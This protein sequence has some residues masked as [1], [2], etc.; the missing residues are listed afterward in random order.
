MTAVTSGT[1][2]PFANSVL[3]IAAGGLAMNLAYKVFCEKNENKIYCLQQQILIAVVLAILIGVILRGCLRGAEPAD[4]LNEPFVDLE[5]ADE[6]PQQLRS[7]GEVS[8]LQR[9]TVIHVFPRLCLPN[10]LLK[11]FAPHL[12]QCSAVAR[13]IQAPGL[14]EDLGPMTAPHV[15]YQSARPPRASASAKEIRV[16]AGHCLMRSGPHDTRGCTFACTNFV[17]CGDLVLTACLCTF[18]VSV[19]SA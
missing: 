19:A 15:R 16:D 18:L 12:L 5:A 3:K 2:L 14:L 17:L 8:D 11:P 10:L 1:V 13:A 4:G 6:S 9:L 7:V